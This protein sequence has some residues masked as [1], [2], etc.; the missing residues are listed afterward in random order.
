[1]PSGDKVGELR[2][3]EKR[4]STTVTKITKNLPGREGMAKVTDN[5]E[6]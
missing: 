6:N 4:H 5:N 3:I 2:L 1:M